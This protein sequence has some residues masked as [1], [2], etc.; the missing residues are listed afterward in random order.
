M[1]IEKLEQGIK[2]TVKAVDKKVVKL[3]K[4]CKECNRSD[5]EFSWLSSLCKACRQEADAW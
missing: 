2:P 1:G 4:R 3:P 5:V